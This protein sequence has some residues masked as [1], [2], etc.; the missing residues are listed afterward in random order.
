MTDAISV[1]HN[2]EVAH[3]LYGLPGKCQ[4]IHGHSMWVTMKLYGNVITENGLLAGLDFADV[5]KTFRDHLDRR[6][7]HHLLLNEEDPWAGPLVHSFKFDDNSVQ[8]ETGRVGNLPGVTTFP[9]D[10]TTENIARRIG[11]WAIDMF[12]S[13][14]VPRVDIEVQETHVNFAH[15]SSAM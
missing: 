8:P 10:P 14:A 4:N 6:Y 3:R 2:I 7:D 1:R 9:C 11:V 5:K 12:I 15:W 13:K